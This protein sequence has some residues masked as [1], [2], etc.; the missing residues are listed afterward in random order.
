M[1]ERLGLGQALAGSCVLSISALLSVW[2]PV[3][4]PGLEPRGLHDCVSGP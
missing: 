1:G 2:L 3:D 4:G